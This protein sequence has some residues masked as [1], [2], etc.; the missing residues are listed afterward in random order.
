MHTML[1]V[2]QRPRLVV[3]DFFYDRVSANKEC[4]Q[5]VVTVPLH[6]PSTSWPPPD[7]DRQTALAVSGQFSGIAGSLVPGGRRGSMS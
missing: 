3:P 1:I 7:C 5:R 4:P 6:K 2:W